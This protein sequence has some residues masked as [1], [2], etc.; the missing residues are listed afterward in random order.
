MCT[1]YQRFRFD[2]RRIILRPSFNRFNNSR[3]RVQI[4]NYNR[5]E[6]LA[7][8][9]PNAIFSRLRMNEN[10]G[11]CSRLGGAPFWRQ[12]SASDLARMAASDLVGVVRYSLCFVDAR[13][14][15]SAKESSEEFGRLVNI[16]LGFTSFP[17][18]EARV[19]ESEYLLAMLSF[20]V[21]KF[22]QLKVISCIVP[23]LD[24]PIAC[25]QLSSLRNLCKNVVD[26]DLSKVESMKEAIGRLGR[27]EL[28][29]R[30]KLERTNREGS[31]FSGFEDA[32]NHIVMMRENN[33]AIHR[34]ERTCLGLERQIARSNCR[35]ELLTREA[36]L[37]EQLAKGDTSCLQKELDRIISELSQACGNDEPRFLREC[38]YVLG[39]SI[40][41]LEDLDRLEQCQLEFEAKKANLAVMSKALADLEEQL[42]RAF[43]ELATFGDAS[44]LLDRLAC[45]NETKLE[46][47]SQT[48]SLVDLI[49]KRMQSARDWMEPKLSELAILRKQVEASEAEAIEGGCLEECDAAQIG[50]DRETLNT[51]RAKLVDSS[52]L[53]DELERWSNLVMDE[54]RFE[55]GLGRYSS[56]HATLGDFVASE[57]NRLEKTESANAKIATLTQLLTQ[58]LE[59]LVK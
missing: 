22:N 31:R 54:G 8:S 6:I 56:E 10:E 48:S 14:A 13:L 25:S 59:L 53:R 35:L 26:M 52:A 39:D 9:S 49:S 41:G 7:W 55:K 43:S 40:F 29:L 36:E 46:I 18:S 17:V 38:E 21:T 32:V 12:I 2:R 50:R 15:A 58:N 16:F 11:I 1:E 20:I 23:L 27:A 34:I 42:V 37:M 47:L 33:E 4:R 57:I 44:N 51:L 5:N 24:E 45:L 28:V 3:N 19:V 30:K